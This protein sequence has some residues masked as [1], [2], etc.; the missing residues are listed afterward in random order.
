M[1]TLYGMKVVVSEDKPKMKLAPGDYVTPE[2][3]KEIDQWLVEF[4]GY[5]SLVPD[6]QVMVMQTHNTVLV[7]QRTYAKLRGVS[8]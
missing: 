3:L 8:K 7:N 4:F 6:G 2:F 1:H 5:T